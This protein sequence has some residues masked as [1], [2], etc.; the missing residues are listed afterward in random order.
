MMHQP[1]DGRGG[2]HRVFEDAVPLAEDQV[3]AD[4]HAFALI[5]FR[6]EGKQYL[7]LIAVLL[8]VTDV[9]EDDCGIAIEAAQFFL[10]R[11]VFSSLGKIADTSTT[12]LS[13]SGVK[14]IR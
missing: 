12:R 14:I 10:Y 13:R 1:V 7:H 4:E 5:P 9:I 8:E 11:Y 6:E 2:G 3:A